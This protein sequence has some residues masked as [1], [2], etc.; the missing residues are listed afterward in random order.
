MAIKLI[1]EKIIQQYDLRNKCKNGFVYM[2]IEKGVYGLPQAGILANKLLWEQLTKRGYFELPHT[3]GLWTHVHR[4][5]WF[6][7]V[8]DY[9]RVKFFGKEHD[10]H[11]LDTLKE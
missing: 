2:Q 6:T 10:Q 4:P 8:V 3:P 11:L 1:P 5:V 9:F 7:L